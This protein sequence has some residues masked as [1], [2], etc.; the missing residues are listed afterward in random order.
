[1]CGVQQGF[2]RA[3]ESCFLRAMQTLIKFVCCGSCDP[4]TITVHRTC[5]WYSFIDT[6]LKYNKKF[7]AAEVVDC[8]CWHRRKKSDFSYFFSFRSK[9]RPSLFLF[10]PIITSIFIFRGFREYKNRGGVVVINRRDRI[11][12]TLDTMTE[13]VLRES[14]I[15][16]Q[17]HLLYS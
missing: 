8:L 4:W 17:L 14:P 12:R 2:V 3:W 1:M 9:S 11:C 10:F 5:T 15:T 6:Y 7:R 13:S 16:R